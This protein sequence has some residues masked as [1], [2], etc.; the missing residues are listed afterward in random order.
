MA[1]CPVFGVAWRMR[2]VGYR[3]LSQ[4]QPHTALEAQTAGV[5]DRTGATATEVAEIRG[6]LK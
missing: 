6:T 2:P 1:T 4:R 3:Y 5:R